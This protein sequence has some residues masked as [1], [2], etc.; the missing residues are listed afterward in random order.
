MNIEYP[1]CPV[2]IIPP[3]PDSRWTTPPDPH[4]EKDVEPP[5][6]MPE[7]LTSGK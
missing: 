6:K 7:S 1:P 3:P 5:A 4:W 2:C